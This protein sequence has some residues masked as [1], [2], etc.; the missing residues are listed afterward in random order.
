MITDARFFLKG[1]RAG[2]LLIHGLTGT[3]SEMQILGK[4][5]NKAGFTVYGMQ[6]AGHCGDEADLLQ[7]RWQDWYDSVNRAAD[8]LLRHTDTLFVGGLSMGAVLALKLAADRPLDVQGLGIYGPTF[9]YD[10]WTIPIYA[11]RLTFLLQWFNR[12]HYLRRKIFIE[13]PPYGLK[14]ERIRKTV[15]ESMLSGDS[16]G[17][18]LAGNPLGSLAEMQKLAKITKAQLDQVKAPCLIMHSAHDD[19]ASMDTNS[20]LVAQSVSGKVKVVRLENSYHLITIDRDR[21]AVIKDSI[22]FFTSLCPKTDRFVSINQELVSQL[23]MT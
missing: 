1:G 15:S 21:K 23:E 8:R 17:A 14:D 10:G 4:G 5:L 11:R 13:R 3:P 9:V 20:G 2:V 12:S 16:A 18:G 22:D 19:I 6:L 7:T